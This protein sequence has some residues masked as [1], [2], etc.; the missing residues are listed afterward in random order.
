MSPEAPVTTATFPSRSIAVSATRGPEPLRAER[1][2]SN[3]AVVASQRLAH[4]LVRARALVP[5]EL[6]AE[7]LLELGGG[8][9]LGRLHDRVDD[10]AILVVRQADHARRRDGRVLVEGGFDLGRIH[11]RA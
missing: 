11:V 10:I 9:R 7:E 3:L 5:C 1:R 4:E 2:A 6:R 8:Q